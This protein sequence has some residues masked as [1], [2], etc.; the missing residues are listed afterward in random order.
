[1]C[2]WS[3]NRLGLAG[4]KEDGIFKKKITA[5]GVV[6]KMGRYIWILGGDEQE[7]RDVSRFCG[8]RVVIK[9]PLVLG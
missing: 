3:S 9:E 6:V 7:L 8:R 2:V 5:G 4:G 1:M